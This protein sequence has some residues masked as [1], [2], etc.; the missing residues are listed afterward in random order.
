[1]I[2][3]SLS[4]YGKCLAQAYAKHGEVVVEI[5]EAWNPTLVRCKRLDHAEPIALMRL[6]QA[7]TADDNMNVY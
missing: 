2:R 4:V 3:S 7:V 5:P 6:L 1:M